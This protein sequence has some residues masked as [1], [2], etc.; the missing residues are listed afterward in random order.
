MGDV[1]GTYRGFADVWGDVQR[2]GEHKNVMGDVEMY[3]G[4]TDI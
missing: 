2:Y 3:G 4:H 1:L